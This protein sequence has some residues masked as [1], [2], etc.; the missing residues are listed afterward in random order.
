MPSENSKDEPSTAERSCREEK[1]VIAAPILP[2]GKRSLSEGFPVY[3]TVA[4][5]VHLSHPDSLTRLMAIRPRSIQSRSLVVSFHVP[6][7]VQTKS[8]TDEGHKVDYG[9]GVDIV[10]PPPR[11]ERVTKRR[12]MQRRNSKTPAMLRAMSLNASKIA[13]EF[14]H[15]GELTGNANVGKTKTFR[16]PKI[17]FEAC[18][19]R[20]LEGIA[21]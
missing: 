15:Q 8:D 14:R 6:Q 19:H 5:H 3:Q 21:F 13:S 16:S 17:L 7:L 11:D 18:K 2:A 10:S 9:Y 4:S 20:G 12:R 1:P